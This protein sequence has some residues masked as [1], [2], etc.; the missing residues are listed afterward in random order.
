MAKLAVRVTEAIV[1]ENMIE[2]VS[3]QRISNHEDGRTLY[4]RQTTTR[5][6]TTAADTAL[7]VTVAGSGGS[8]PGA[9]S[10]ASRPP[11]VRDPQ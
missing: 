10:N 5:R 4:L 2:T 9:P 3:R 7:P 1:F 6:G 8:H 11:P